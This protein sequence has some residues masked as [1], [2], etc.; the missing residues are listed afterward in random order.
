MI[1]LIYTASILFSKGLGESTWDLSV[2]N[3][4]VAGSEGILARIGELVG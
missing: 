3:P 2:K 1:Q 4:N